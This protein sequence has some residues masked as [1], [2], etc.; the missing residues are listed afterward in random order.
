MTHSYLPGGQ[1]WI[2]VKCRLFSPV[3]DVQF[4][5]YSHHDDIGGR[6]SV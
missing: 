4:E 2:A 5:R 3:V 1:N 6:S